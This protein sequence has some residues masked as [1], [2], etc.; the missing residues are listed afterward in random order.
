[1]ASPGPAAVELPPGYEEHSWEPPAEPA[2]APARITVRPERTGAPPPS[3]IPEGYEEVRDAPER[4]PRPTP[5][6][7]TWQRLLIETENLGRA[8]F[9]LTT[10]NVEAHW[11]NYLGLAQNDEQGNVGY[12]ESPQSFKLTDRNKHVVLVDPAD[13]QMKVFARTENTDEG[14][15]SA[16]GHIAMPG[17][18]TTAISRVGVGAG[19][20]VA[21]ALNPVTASGQRI[22]VDIPRVISS[23]IP[24]TRLVGQVV[25]KAPGGG[26]LHTGIERAV[27]GLGEATG[28]AA[29]RAGGRAPVGGAPGTTADEAGAAFRAGHTQTFEH[30][31]PA[32]VSNLYDRVDAL[33]NPSIRTD[34]A[35]TRAIS[36]RILAARANFGK[37]DIPKVIEDTLG[38]ITNP[39]GVN[40]AG[41][42]GL[43]SEVGELYNK[44]PDGTILKQHLDAVYKGLSEDLEQAVR[45]A[46]GREA[47]VAWQRA[48]QAKSLAAQWQERV[49]KV[50]GSETSSNEDIV[51]RIKAMAG[52]GAGADIR[53]LMQ[54]RAAIPESYWRHV[55]GNVINGLGRNKKGEF[56][57]AQFLN[58]YNAL[59]Q[60]GKRV[61]FQGTGSGDVIP[62]LEDIATS[63]RAFIRAGKLANPSGSAGHLAT[64]GIGG[65]VVHVAETGEWKH[66]LYVLG[67]VIGNNVLARFLSRPSTAAST[68]RWI[69]AY[70]DY[71]A[72]PS[73]PSLT[74]L[75]RVTRDLANTG[76]LDVDK[77]WHG[78]GAKAEEEGPEPVESK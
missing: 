19:P 61:L 9:Q 53:T 39:E 55:A 74:S 62:F 6:T 48:N 52:T 77:L 57:P 70:N 27:E 3:D 44:T 54:A 78:T 15:I 13:G 33:V 71:V 37:E 24:G 67:S 23:N 66:G 30:E 7:G 58:D 60:A 10:P 14:R 45:N 75:N 76:G 11:P 40:Y 47:L 4:P 41:I 49:S 68:A 22:G 64:I 16:L 35:A 12:W 28:A 38:A 46:G 43:R 25:S 8:G 42:K 69:R 32:A 72:K 26:P 20:A 56:S 31:I 21:P 1:M 63:S 17:M 5:T 59:S 2:T 51:R 34:M 73:V 29:E 36:D 65:A 18:G 50:L